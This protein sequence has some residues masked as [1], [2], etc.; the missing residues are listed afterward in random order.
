[1]PGAALDLVRTKASG[2]NS[3]PE[4]VIGWLNAIL[5]LAPEDSR[6]LGDVRRNPP[7]FILGQ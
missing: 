4:N 5:A 3:A 1:M 6:Q 7:R 2:Q